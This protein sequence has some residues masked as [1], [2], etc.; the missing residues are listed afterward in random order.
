VRCRVV[1]LGCPSRQALAAP[2]GL[3]DL[4]DLG[5]DRDCRAA[6]LGRLAR[7]FAADLIYGHLLDADDCARIA[8]EGVPLVLTVHNQRPG[9]PEGLA[10]R[11]AGDAALLVACA[12]AVEA[13]LVGAGLPVP[14]RTAWNGIEPDAFAP[15][16]ARVA[17]GRAFRRQWRIG[18]GD[19]VLLA[20]A[21]P[22]PQKRLD[23]LP[24][25]LAAVRAELAR[26]GVQRE[27]R[28]VIAGEASRRAPPR[29]RRS[30]RSTP[31]SNGW[32]WQGTSGGRGRSPTWPPRWPRPTCWSRRATTR[33]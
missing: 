3:I 27:A 7:A 18:P 32:A 17:A 9:W 8:R 30:R 21:N 12:R 10:E 11:G 14:V 5:A 15:T 23:R 4:S 2:V 24:A 33:G 19:L 20:L 6:A 29:S 1:T 28:L 31:R 13:E 25:V 22:R 16:P 26:R